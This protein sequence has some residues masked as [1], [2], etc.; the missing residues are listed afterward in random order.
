VSFEVLQIGEVTVVTDA[1]HWSGAGIWT[2][3]L[4]DHGDSK[5]VLRRLSGE[6]WYVGGGGPDRG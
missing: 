3:A 6:G 1:L 2:S 4:A 5:G